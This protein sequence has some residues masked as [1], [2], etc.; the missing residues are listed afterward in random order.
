MAR[1]GPAEFLRVAL[2]RPE[3]RELVLRVMAA[4]ELRYPGQKLYVPFN[5]G[6]RAEGVQAAIYA[7][8]TRAGFRA[9]PPGHSPHEYGA[10]I[11]LQIVGTKQDAD[12][13][14]ADPRYRALADIAVAHGLTA[15]FYFRSGKPDPYHLELSEPLELMRS[16]WDGLKKKGSSRLSSSPRS[17]L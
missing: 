16:T 11:D 17:E 12:R 15:G 10:A 13:D 3:L 2:V 6:Y 8:S 7:D 5:G 1:F 4:W 9:A 14:Q